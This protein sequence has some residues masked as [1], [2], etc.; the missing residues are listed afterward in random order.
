LEGF[1]L[2]CSHHAR[3]DAFNPLWRRRSVQS[4]Q[5]IATGYDLRRNIGPGR[6]THIGSSIGLL[7]SR[8]EKK[9]IKSA[10]RLLT[11]SVCITALAAIPTVT[12]VEAA[13]NKHGEV[14]KNRRKIQNGP[15]IS[16]RRSSNPAWPPP[17]YDDPDR[18]PG[19]GGGM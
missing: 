8:Q 10:I 19:G 11:V 9:L 1:G 5:G 7:Q 12:S 13:A 16:N 6:R 18:N 3:T 4:L 14:E 2:G 15:G 17:M